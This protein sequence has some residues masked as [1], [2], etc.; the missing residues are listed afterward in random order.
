MGNCEMDS[1]PRDQVNHNPSTFH[2][3][4]LKHVE[5]EVQVFG[6]GERGKKSQ[7]SLPE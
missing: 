3:N 6:L 7:E 2:G 5:V 1:T 4:I